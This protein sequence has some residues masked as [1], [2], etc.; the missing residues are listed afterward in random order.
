[1]CH[2]LSWIANLVKILLNVNWEKQTVE[3]SLTSKNENPFSCDKL[4]VN[5]MFLGL[6]L[7]EEQ[8]VVNVFLTFKKYKTIASIS[9]IC[10]G[11]KA[12]QAL[13]K[14]M[15]HLKPKKIL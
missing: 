3:R 7:Y 13:M 12:R 1:M 9:P 10:Y 14:K 5:F 4:K 15:N 6:N 2:I 11:F 8:T